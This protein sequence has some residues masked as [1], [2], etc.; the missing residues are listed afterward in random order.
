MVRHQHIGVQ[1]AVIDLHGM[2]EVVKI[3]LIVDCRV[4]TRLAV[5][6]ALDDVLGDTR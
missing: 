6:A 4:K 5:I 1:I 2:L 3:T